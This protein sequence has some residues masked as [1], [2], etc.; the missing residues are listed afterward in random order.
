MNNSDQR[1]ES[2][3]ENEIEIQKIAPRREDDETVFRNLFRPAR[4][5]PPIWNSNDDSLCVLK[6]DIQEFLILATLYS[7]ILTG[8]IIFIVSHQRDADV[9]INNDS[10]VV[11]SWWLWREIG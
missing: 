6:F 10:I 11:H 3:S 9:T 8:F 2:S 7:F 4:Q 5:C 1:R